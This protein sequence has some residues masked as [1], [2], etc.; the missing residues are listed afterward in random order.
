[1]VE[2]EGI[3]LQFGGQE[4]LICKDVPPTQKS[5]LYRI[6]FI[7][8]SR[9]ADPLIAHEAQISYKLLHRGVPFP[10]KENV[11]LKKYQ[12]SFNAGQMGGHASVLI[13]T[14]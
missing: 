4:G 6:V 3:K 13:Q 9:I 1:V 14:A 2:W 12:S 5:N 10:I 8:W 7:Q 11:T